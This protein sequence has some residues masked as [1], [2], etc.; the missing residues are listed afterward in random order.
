MAN[1]ETLKSTKKSSK[2]INQLNYPS[3]IRRKGSYNEFLSSYCITN[4][5]V[6]RLSM[7][8]VLQN[9][10]KINLNTIRMYLGT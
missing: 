9:L 2:K 3:S 8:R 4:N 10:R 5:S 6:K 1:N 7:S